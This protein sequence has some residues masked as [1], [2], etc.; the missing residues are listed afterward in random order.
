M[1]LPNAC[2]FAFVS[3]Q[4]VLALIFLCSHSSTPSLVI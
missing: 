2:F 1:F 3:A 4:S